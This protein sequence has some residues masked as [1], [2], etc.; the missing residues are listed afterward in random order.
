[1]YRGNVRYILGTKGNMTTFFLGNT[2]LI[3]KYLFDN[4]GKPYYQ[5]RVPKEIQPQLGIKKISVPLDPANGSPVTQVNRLAKMHDDLFKVMRSDNSIVGMPEKRKAAMLLLNNFNLQGGAGSVEL[6]PSENS[7]WEVNPTPHIDA[8]TD[9]LENKN[10]DGTINEVD[11]LALKALY[12]PLPTLLSEVPQ[13]Y[14]ENHPKGGDERFKSKQMQYWNKLLRINGDM[15]ITSLSREAAKSFKKIRESENVKSASVQKDINV[16]KAMLEKAITE[17]SININNPFKD[18]VATNL[19]KD[20]IPREV[21]SS[22]ELQEIQERC[23]AQDDDVRRLILILMFTGARLGEIV[24]LRKQDC[25]LDEESPHIYLVEYKNRSLKNKN[26]R[27]RV[28][29]MPKALAAL[30]RQLKEANGSTVFTRYC[31][32]VDAPNADSASACINDWLAKTTNKTTHSFRHTVRGLLR[33]ADVP[34]D[35]SQEIGGWG[36]QSIG[37]TYGDRSTLKRKL[38]ALKRGFDLAGM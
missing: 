20:S 18:I 35:L 29:L 22:N 6:D 27:R 10:R 13:I 12:K 16:I 30:K 33:N 7:G 2:R 11:K 28:P 24:G 36:S 3:V 15:P 37:D 19:G 32:G 31:N 25:F 14:F 38:S 34:L 5:R 1:M 9:Y 23:L 17:L 4:N 26:S 8:F 21:F